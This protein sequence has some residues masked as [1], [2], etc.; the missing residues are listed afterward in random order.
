MVV[1]QLAGDRRTVK[2]S[3]RYGHVGIYMIHSELLPDLKYALHSNVMERL[4]FS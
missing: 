1:S 4:E 2:E 3:E